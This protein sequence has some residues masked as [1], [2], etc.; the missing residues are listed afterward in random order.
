MSSAAGPGRPRDPDV[1]A[2]VLGAAAA[3]LSERGSGG[4]TMELVAERAGVS[5][6]SLYRRYCNRAE[7]LEAT[8][9]KFAPDLPP[10]PDTGDV[11][12]DLMVLLG[13][14]ADSLAQPTDGVPLAALLAASASNREARAAVRR[15]NDSRRKPVTEVIERGRARGQ[16]SAAID[17]EAVAEML[18]G[19]VLFRTLVRGEDVDEQR[20]RR[21]VA[22]VD[23]TG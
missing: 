17:S 21:Y 2:A 16:V 10:T 6:A 1:D 8:C 12:T 9:G 7:L 13:N 23:L 5:K 20:L 19:A 3:I 15:F 11:R 14:I 18:A 22:M 4:L